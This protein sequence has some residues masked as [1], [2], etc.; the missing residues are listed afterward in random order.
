MNM[1][2]IEPNWIALL[3]F[4][5]FATVITIA[6]LGVAGM[7]PFES[8]PSEEKSGTGTLLIIGNS[9][10]L[11]TLLAGT[12]FY[13]YSEL[14]WSTLFFVTGLVALFAQGHFEIGPSSDG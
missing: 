9:V 4:A 10:L 8:P 7:F 14:R 3:W 13:G 6:F 1:Q 2:A 5:G 11:A 12:A